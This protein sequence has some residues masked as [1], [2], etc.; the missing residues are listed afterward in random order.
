M[1]RKLPTVAIVG[2]PNVG[3]STLFN[4]LIQK[5]ISIMHDEPGVTRD[6]IYYVCDWLSRKFNLID[7]GGFSNNLNLTFQAEIN[8]QVEISMKEADIIIFLLSAVDGV[9][10]ED[11]IISKLL[12]KLGKKVIIAINK[13]DNFEMVI[14]TNNFYS[15][16]F[17]EPI[18][19]SSIHGIGISNLLDKVI[20]KMVKKDS[21]INNVLRIGIIGKT[22][23]GKSTLVNAWLQ[24]NRTIV[25][26][27]AG[28]T[29]DSI[30]TFLKINGKDIILTD[31]AG[32]KKNKKTLNDIE[33]YAEL[34]TQ[35]TIMN[36]DIIVMLIDKG[37]S[38]TNI[39]EKI[40]GILKDEY[41]PV[42]IAINKVDK[43]NIDEKKIIKDEIRSKLKFIPWVPVMLISAKNRKNIDKSI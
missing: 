39:D 30:D 20:E 36:S 1:D 9:T 13:A 22:N 17:G 35:L 34:R 41:K 33:W 11:I 6:R 12:R 27:I 40:I 7:S 43:L 23:V 21:L 18:A 16:G 3:K 29:R 25:S 2:R 5:R 14:S 26:N 38:I 19:I 10:K 28:T 37:Q 42:I 8:T 15:L 31:T 24:N 4:R 32:L